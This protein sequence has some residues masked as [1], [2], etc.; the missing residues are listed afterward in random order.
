MIRRGLILLFVAGMLLV[1][2]VPSHAQQITSRY[3]DETGHSVKDE[4]LTFYLSAPDPLLVYGLPITEAFID[5]LNKN[6]KMQYFQRA[7]F[8]LDP[9][10]AAGKRVKLSDL[11]LLTYQ[12]SKV[13]Q[14]NMA[15]NT[16]ACRQYK[17]FFVCYAFLAFF[18]AHGGL[19]QFG[20]PISNY[21]KEGDQYI[22]YFERAR[23]EYHPELS[24]DVWVRL[25]DIGRIQ[26]DQSHRDPLLLKAISGGNNRLADFQVTR[27]QLRAY[28]SKAVVTANSKQ[29]L[30]V[31]VL[32]QFYHPV[33]QA[34]V[35]VNVISPGAQPLPVEMRPTDENGVSRTDE[36]KVGDLKPNQIVLVEVNVTFGDLHAATTTWYHVW[37]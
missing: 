34:L 11:G 23:F 10:A 3:F 9:N 21:S 15:T 19:T 35:A 29:G 18:D 16:P 28:A 13:Q 2:L 32:D 22:Q 36:I 14:V 30:T 20:Y 7:R 17:D 33:A 1:T 6:I 26:F 8:E 4:F 12:A 37:W 24:N 25:T 5:P 31:I 27:L